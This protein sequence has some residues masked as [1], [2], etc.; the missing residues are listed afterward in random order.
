[1]RVESFAAR[2]GVFALVVLVACTTDDVDVDPPDTTPVRNL[3]PLADEAFAEYLIFLDVPGVVENDAGAATRYSLDV[4]LVDAVTELALSKTTS[5]IEMLEMA[6]VATATTKIGSVDGLQHFVN[7][8]ELRLTSNVITALDTRALSKLRVLEMNFNL[9]GQLDLR[10]NSELVRLRYKASGGASDAQRLRQIDLSANTA[11]THLYLPGHDLQAIDLSAN[12]QLN[13]TLDLSDNPGPDGDRSTGDIVV[14]AAIYNQ[15]PE[16]NRLGV[17]SD[18]DAPVQLSLTSQAT[19]F[20]ENGGTV[21][22]TAN[23]NR[24]AEDTVS[25]RLALAGTAVLGTDYRVDTTTLT[26]ALGQTMASAV[27]TGIDDSDEEGAETVEVMA[28]NITNAQAAVVDL[29]LTIADDDIQIFLLLNEVLYDPPRNDEGDGDANGDGGRDPNEDEFVEILNVGP[30]PVDLSGFMMFDAEAVAMDTPRHTIPA[31][32]VLAPD[33]ALVVFGG[34][35]PQG[36]FG[37]AIVQTANG[38]EGA[39]NLNNS[40]DVFV[41]QNASG[42]EIIN[43]DIEPLSNNPNESY[44]RA[45]D[46]SGEFVQHSAAVPNVLYSPGTR[47]DGTDF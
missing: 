15:V 9:V 33:Q 11:L 28:T 41:L 31:G 25:L 44:T 1:M 40:G 19:S 6:S 36:S 3:F 10:Q 35:S 16:M 17:I 5:A 4:D 7:L 26:I 14:P 13:D 2:V 39:L 20:S 21:T 37:G 8:E 29:A 47:I 38:F 23:L 12:L 24:V 43:F 46:V 27:F 30:E 22:I 34:G 45:P 42:A 32:T 18:A